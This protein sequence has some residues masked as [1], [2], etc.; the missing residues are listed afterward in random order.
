MIQRALGLS[1]DACLLAFL[2][3]ASAGAAEPRAFVLDAGGGSV[4]AMDMATG[5]VL[6]TAPVQGSPAHM[7]RTPDGARLVV[8]DPGPGKMTMRFGIHPTGKATATVLDAASLKAV[9]RVEL[10]FNLVGLGRA[11]YFSADGKRLTV[12]CSGYRSRKPEETLPAE[13]VTVDLESGAVSGRLTLDR[14]ADQIVVLPD[15]QG[16]VAFWGRETPKNA[17]AVPAEAA[18]VDFAG[19]RIAA[20]LKL[21]GS[22]TGPVLAPEGKGL[23]FF[24]PRVAP[25]KKPPVGAGLQF[26]DLGTREIAATLAVEG[27]PSELAFSRDGRFLYL[28]ETGRPD[29][30]PEKNVAGRIQVY[31][32]ETR[33]H[34]TNLEAG[35][36]PRG[37]I[38]DDDGDQV[39]VLSEGAPSL[40]KGEP[41]GELRV[42]RGAEIAAVVK[43][44]SEPSFLRIS[45]D[46]AR[47][48]VVGGRALSH[49]DL[50]SLRRIA[51]T[52]M[53][54]AGINV[55]SANPV[56]H[57]VSELA[58]SDDGRR[59]F[60]LYSGSSKLS[61]LDLESQKLI[62]EVTT[63]RG[64]KKFAKFMGALA[65]S[66]AMTAA[67]QSAGRN[68]AMYSGSSF[69]TYNVYNFQVAAPNT[70]L[71]VRPDG[72]FA[73]ALNTQTSDVTIVNAD[74]G[75]VV[76]KLGGG[77]EALRL[78]TGGSVLAVR[79][80]DALRL[81][82]TSTQKK[83][84]ELLFPDS[85]SVS[86][87]FS[88]DGV[89]AIAA[90]GTT[91]YCLDGSTAKVRAR[92]ATFKKAVY[93]VV[94]EPQA[95]QADA[96][97]EPA[98]GAPAP[99]P[100]EPAAPEPAPEEPAP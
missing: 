9:S 49:V 20:R 31:S 84:D 65:V 58:V 48:Y 8:L 40:E 59:G 77:G 14:P 37:F 67:S 99:G 73:Y 82:D 54:P 12:F 29:K 81:I 87:V 24:S 25:K 1:L 86:L 19:P 36:D 50:R 71:A 22:P 66:V 88:P 56:R 21:E 11:P 41:E 64:G 43:V 100:P 16:A 28:L 33:A 69:Y 52:P 6:A 55:L 75:Q 94:E 70:S 57:T 63:G 89:H 68:M 44:A 26:V 23:V 62:D 46:R 4:V 92:H 2:A 76:D 83:G 72:K 18:F 5:A 85:S 39:L 34:E 53:K 47:L 97:P 10:G 15:G 30:K 80:K 98:P 95:A 27:D 91:V 79:D 51:D 78:F 42:L 45:P 60:A 13:V 38:A 90:G 17:P 96:A 7:V 3:V 32:T 74:T 35:T 93:V 61:I